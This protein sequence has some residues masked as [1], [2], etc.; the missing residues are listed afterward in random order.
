MI[1]INIVANSNN[2]VSNV[3]FINAIHDLYQLNK[4]ALVDYIFMTC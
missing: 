3:E 1:C 2:V 4:P